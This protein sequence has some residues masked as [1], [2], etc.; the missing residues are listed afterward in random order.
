MAL[1]AKVRGQWRNV[2]KAMARVLRAHGVKVVDTNAPAEVIAETVGIAS[3]GLA[4]KIDAESFQAAAET[5]R[6]ESDLTD[7]ELERL[8]APGG[9]G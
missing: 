7:D 9:E 8:T 2:S 1:R 3:T 4:D 6:T 5:L